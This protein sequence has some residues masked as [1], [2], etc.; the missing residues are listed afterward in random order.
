MSETRDRVKNPSINFPESQDEALRAVIHGVRS[1]LFSPHS[2]TY[3]PLS[4]ERTTDAG[5]GHTRSQQQTDW[6][7]EAA[8]IIKAVIEDRLD[9]MERAV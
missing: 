7:N 5:L 8:S 4:E 2:G 9:D 6:L 3:S 1:T